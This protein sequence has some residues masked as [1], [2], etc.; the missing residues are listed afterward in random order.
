MD[1][2][3]YV[4]GVFFLFCVGSRKDIFGVDCTGDMTQQCGLLNCCQ[5]VS[6]GSRKDIFGVDCTGDMTQQCGLLNCCQAVSES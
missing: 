2:T 6:V 3:L 4:L 1:G 5:A